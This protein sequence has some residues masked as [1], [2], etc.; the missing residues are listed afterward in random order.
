VRTA[1]FLHVLG[2]I[3]WAGGALNLSRML[4]FHVQEEL[5][6]QARFSEM[7]IKIFFFVTLP[8]MLLAVA[9]G[10]YMLADPVM[11]LISH[12]WMKAKLGLA[13]LFIILTFELGR[14]IMSLRG[15]PAKGSKG[16][17]MAL[18]GILGLSLMGILY[19]VFLQPF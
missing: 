8:G 11:N 12:D 9:A 17:Q 16:A 1:L 13:L 14:R 2:V 6:V 10:L 4:A 15:K 7:E 3:L 19:L 18:H 5:G